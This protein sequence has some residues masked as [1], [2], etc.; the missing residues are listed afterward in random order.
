MPVKWFPEEHPGPYHDHES[1]LDQI[2][3]LSKQR[4]HDAIFNPSILALPPGSKYQ[5]LVVARSQSRN[6]TQSGY[7]LLQRGTVPYCFANM[8]VA[9]L[10]H[11]HVIECLTLPKDLDVPLPEKQWLARRNHPD[12]QEASPKWEY[13]RWDMAIGPEDP[14]LTW[15]GKGELV[16][17]YGQTSAGT[18]SARGIWIASIHHFLPE[19]NNVLPRSYVK[20]LSRSKGVAAY[21][22]IFVEPKMVEKVRLP[23]RKLTPR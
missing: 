13:T 2:N 23:A 8:T 15:G 4:V 5:F 19:L 16:M 18:F 11:T 21:E 7:T 12:F 3:R 20:H 10:A 22:G 14:R 9:N 1:E 17:V 6:N